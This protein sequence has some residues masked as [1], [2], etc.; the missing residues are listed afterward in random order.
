MSAHSKIPMIDDF[1]VSR[2]RFIRCSQLDHLRGVDVAAGPNFG[3]QFTGSD[4]IVCTYLGG[5]G[6]DH[7]PTL[8]V[9]GAGFFNVVSVPEPSGAVLGLLA[10]LALRIRSK[11]R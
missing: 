7:T 8:T 6:W 4:G 2:F 9:G 5:G 1:F 10:V 11:K 3:E